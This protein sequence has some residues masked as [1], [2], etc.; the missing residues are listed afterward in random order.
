MNKQEFYQKISEMRAL[1]INKRY[2]NYLNLHQPILNKYLAAI[3]AITPE[4]AKKPGK[5]GRTIAQVVGHIAEWERFIY[6]SLEEIISGVKK[7]KF[8]SFKGFIDETGEI[9][10]FESIDEFN[11]LQSE[12]YEDCSWAELQKLAID[13]SEKIYG[14][15]SSSG[16]IS[17]ELL[18][19]TAPLKNNEG[20]QVTTMGW[21]LWVIAMEHG[22]FEHGLD[23]G[24]VIE[25]S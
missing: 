14:I 21:Q 9:H 13:I 6:Q 16:S 20:V 23:L 5:D 15:F 19:N 25:D 4:T 1:E 8:Y 22:T 11:A 12:K 17:P 3:R 24:V 10:D 18:E 7:P 2:D